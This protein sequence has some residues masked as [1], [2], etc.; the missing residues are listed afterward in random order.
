MYYL[1]D[2]KWYCAQCF[3]PKLADLVEWKHVHS[4]LKFVLCS[5]K[6]CWHKAQLLCSVLYVL[7]TCFTNIFCCLEYF[8]I[9]FTNL[10]LWKYK[11]KNETSKPLNSCGFFFILIADWCPSLILVLAWY[12]IFS[13]I[14][15]NATKGI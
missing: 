2:M 15:Y 14:W 8:I 13:N 1:R 3:M 10:I 12:Y 7:H 11:L 9:L 4:I 5:P 6:W